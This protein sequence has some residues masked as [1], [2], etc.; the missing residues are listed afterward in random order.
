VTVR[1]VFNSKSLGSCLCEDEERE[2]VA[3]NQ[4]DDFFR[5]VIASD[6]FTAELEMIQQSRDAFLYDREE[7]LP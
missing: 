1:I 7:H 2:V 5:R 3:I 6:H 4:L